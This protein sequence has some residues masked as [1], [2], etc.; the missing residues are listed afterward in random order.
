MA[1]WENW[2]H[3]TKL[4]PDRKISDRIIKTIVDSG[5]DAIMISGSQR[6][7]KEKVEK[8]LDLLKGYSIPKILEPVDP[9]AVVYKDIDYIFVP[10]VF[11]TN[12]P[13]WINGLHKLWVKADKNINW[14]IVVPEAY[15]IL[16][17][18]CGAARKT[19]A[20]KMKKEDAVAA[21]VCAERYFNFPII[22]IE[23][24]G[25]YGDPELVAAIKASLTKAHLFYGGGI[26]SAQ[27]AEEMSK[28]A[29]IVVG[30]TIYENG[31][32]S[33]L[34]TVRGSFGAFSKKIHLPKIDKK[35]IQNR[36]QRIRRKKEKS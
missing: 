7:T 17:P 18:K 35:D 14:D 19:K 28:Y 8:L 11:N 22:Y 2:K 36:L 34:K 31:T 5:T 16:N 26:N 9:R 32:H 4:D 30:N 6:I 10:T 13:L 29:T 1:V 33:L 20:Y 27:K 12:N 23:Y 15:I 24:S 3:I 25:L 21:A